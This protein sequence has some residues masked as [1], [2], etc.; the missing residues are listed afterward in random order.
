VWG[1]K[2]ASLLWYGNTGVLRTYVLWYNKLISESRG[3]LL[4]RE[5]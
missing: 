3:K 1:T 2:R 4:D 5:P